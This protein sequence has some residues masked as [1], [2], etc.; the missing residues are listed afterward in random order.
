MK[1]FF[2]FFLSFLQFSCNRCFAQNAEQPNFFLAQYFHTQ[3]DSEKSYTN[4]KDSIQIT[5]IEVWITDTAN[6]NTLSYCIAF[7]DI[8]EP[9]P[10]NALLANQ[11]NIQLPDNSSNKLYKTLTS[12]SSFRLNSKVINAITSVPLSLQ[13]KTDFK[14]D[15]FRKL[16]P[17]EFVL[18]PKEGYISLLNPITPKTIVAVAYQY[19]YNGKV[20]QV[21]EFEEQLPISYKNEKL[22]FLKLAK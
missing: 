1:T 3:Y 10:I 22:I 5:R 13:K 21:G 7:K 6:L 20:Y 19:S 9:K 11:K 17:D 2:V 18:K 8:G 14:I 4:N 16:S 12:D 15:Y